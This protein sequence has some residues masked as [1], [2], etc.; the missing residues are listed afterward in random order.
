[1]QEQCCETEFGF[2]FVCIRMSFWLIS[3]EV[4]NNVFTPFGHRSL[5]CIQ[6]FS[7]SF[8]FSLPFFFAI[9]LMCHQPP[10][11]SSAYPPSRT[12]KPDRDTHTHTHTQKHTLAPMFPDVCKDD[13]M[14]DRRHWTLYPSLFQKTFRRGSTRRRSKTLI[15]SQRTLRMNYAW[16]RAISLWLVKLVGFSES[17]PVCHKLRGGLLTIRLYIPWKKCVFKC[18]FI[19]F[20]KHETP[21]LPVV[22]EH[23]DPCVS[24]I[25]SCGFV[26]K[27]V[28]YQWHGEN[29][30]T[31]SL[32]VLFLLLENC[33]A[34]KLQRGKKG[35]M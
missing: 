32:W 13:V 16:I 25:R 24:V 4:E 33:S 10:Y 23:P 17:Q 12:H 29:K 18:D 27:G 21:G 35:A 9:L 28:K 5:L 30:R 31:K 15:S 1:M 22:P 3:A 20:V 2:E 7:F 8:L 34:N 19:L 26:L 6:I 11:S 14:A